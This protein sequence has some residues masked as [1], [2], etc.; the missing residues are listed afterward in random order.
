[1]FACFLLTKYWKSWPFFKILFNFDSVNRMR[2][3]WV[4]FDFG[5]QTSFVI[6][7][8]IVCF[9]VYPHFTAIHCVTQHET[10]L[11]RIY[12]TTVI[13]EASEDKMYFPNYY[14][15][16]WSGFFGSARFPRSKI[17]PVERSRPL[18][19]TMFITVSTLSAYSGAANDQTPNCSVRNLPTNKSSA[20]INS[21]CVSYWHLHRGSCTNLCVHDF[22]I[23]HRQWFE[24]GTLAIQ[25]FRFN[26]PEILCT[27]IFFYLCG[28]NIVAFFPPKIYTSFDPIRRKIE[29]E[30][31]SWWRAIEFINTRNHFISMKIHH[32]YSV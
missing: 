31:F 30:E 14:L 5:N 26:I 6:R 16:F 15:P 21:F 3:L 2:L 1:M 7:T 17:C 19:A 10:I 29:L 25:H 18:H 32:L 27:R 11:H 9:G 8:S 22:Y 20:S 28:F 23:F 13:A 4:C 12:V 24:L